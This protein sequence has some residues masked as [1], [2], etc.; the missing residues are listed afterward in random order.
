MNE[1]RN[2]NQYP[3]FPPNANKTNTAAAKSAKKRA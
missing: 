3:L 2:R 1:K